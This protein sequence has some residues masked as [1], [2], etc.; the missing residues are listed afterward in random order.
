MNIPDFIVHYS[1]SEKLF[2]SL[3][4]VPKENLPKIIGELSEENAWGLDRFLD[5]EYLARRINVE[6]KI[7]KEFVAK[8][9]RPILD[10]PIYLPNQIKNLSVL[11]CRK[12][13]IWYSF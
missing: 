5:P 3:S 2:R 10:H 13:R 11:W 12:V 9:G 4:A 8:G 1:R 6:K 7:R